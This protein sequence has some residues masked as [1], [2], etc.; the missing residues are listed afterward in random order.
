MELVVGKTYKIVG[1]PSDPTQYEL[2]SVVFKDSNGDEIS[3]AP[4]V[5]GNNETEAF[6]FGSELAS[7]LVTIYGT[8]GP[9]QQQTQD[10]DMDNDGNGTITAQEVQ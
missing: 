8:F 5:V 4:S 6:T 1:T 10:V 9:I 7:Q 3:G 2:E